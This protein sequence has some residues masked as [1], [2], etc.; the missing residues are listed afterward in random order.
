MPRQAFG[1]DV[2]VLLLAASAAGCNG[3]GFGLRANSAVSDSR[4][5]VPAPINLMLP[6]TIRIHPFTGTR[7]FDEAGG[8]K[9]VDVRIE[10]IDAYG[11]AVKAF[12]NFRFEMYYFLPN[13]LDPRGERIAVW[14]EDLLEPRKNLMHWDKITRTYEFKLQWDQPIPVG[15]R[16]VL[17]ATFASPFTDRLYDQRVFV[18][19][20]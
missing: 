20:Q 4:R 19:G 3:T 17:E 5:V 16:F 18:S 11:D 9:G 12:G 6:K 1:T 15:Q 8:I 10:A 13:S 7:T 14:E 2:L